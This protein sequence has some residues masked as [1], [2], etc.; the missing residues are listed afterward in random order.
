MLPPAGTPIPSASDGLLGLGCV[1]DPRLHHRRCRLGPRLARVWFPG[2]DGEA[3]AA[4]RPWNKSLRSCP[5]LVGVYSGAGKGFVRAGWTGA[6]GLA[7]V[8]SY[9]VLGLSKIGVGSSALLLCFVRASLERCR[10]IVD[11]LMVVGVLD[12]SG[13]RAAAGWCCAQVQGWSSMGCV[14][15]RSSS[16]VCCICGSSQS[17]CAKVLLQP[18]MPLP[19]SFF[20]GEGLAA[21]GGGRRRRMMVLRSGK[22]LTDLVVIFSLSKVFSAKECGQLSPV[23][24]PSTFLYL[25]CLVFVFFLV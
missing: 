9:P 21:V 24:L 14:P 16:T 4:S 19:F 25:Y 17:L 7:E 15:G 10:G 12:L 6:G 13:S 20:S 3:A 11:G 18:L 1:G 2:G 8:R 5:R 23:Y 22:D